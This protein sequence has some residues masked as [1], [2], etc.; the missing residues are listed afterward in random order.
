M[1]VEEIE[2]PNANFTPPKG[3]PSFSLNKKF[4]KR[5]ESGP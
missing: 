3:A 4:W 2:F 1:M 5:V